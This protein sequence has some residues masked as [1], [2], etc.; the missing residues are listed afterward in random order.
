MAPRTSQKVERNR[1]NPDGRNQF[2]PLRRP[3]HPTRLTRFSVLRWEVEYDRVSA[4]LLAGTV[5]AAS[6]GRGPT[7]PLS[8][9]P[10]ARLLGSFSL[11]RSGIAIQSPRRRGRA[12]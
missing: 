6:H 7:R 4:Y 1:D 8:H 2:A 3:G 12:T 9:A 5:R 10:A 11:Q